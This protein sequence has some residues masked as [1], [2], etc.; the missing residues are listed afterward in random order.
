MLPTRMLGSMDRALLEQLRELPR[1]RALHAFIL[2]ILCSPECEMGSLLRENVIAA[3]AHAIVDDDI[4]SAW[5]IVPQAVCRRLSAANEAAAVVALARRSCRIR[6]ETGSTVTCKMSQRH[7]NRSPRWDRRRRR[8]EFSRRPKRL[9]PASSNGSARWQAHRVRLILDRTAQELDAGALQGAQFQPALRSSRPRFRSGSEP[10][11][12]WPG[13]GALPIA[14]GQPG[15]RQAA[16]SPN[17][18]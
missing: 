1:S 13:C 6:W 16:S 11:T 15:A 4:R 5:T 3:L 17:G 14:H 12:P 9:I 7:L 2:A 10:C 8:I 18:S